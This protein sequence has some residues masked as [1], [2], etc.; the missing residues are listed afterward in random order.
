MN[1]D[2]EIRKKIDSMDLSAPPPENEPERQYYF[3]KAARKLLKEKFEADVASGK[4][5]ER[6]G[7]ERLDEM[8][9]KE[10]FGTC[11]VVTFGCRLNIMEGIV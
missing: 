1:N 8:L 5:L 9:T 6:Y 10:F 2:E 7:K 3:I 11:C 4:A